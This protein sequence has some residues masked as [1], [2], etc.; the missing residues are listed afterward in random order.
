MARR[1]RVRVLLRAAAVLAGADRRAG[2]GRRHRRPHGADRV[3]HRARLPVEPHHQ[4]R[5]GRPRRRAGVARRAAHPRHR[6][7]RTSS[8]SASASRSPSGSGA[9]VEFIFIRRFFKAPRLILTVVTIGV[10]QI[11]AGVATGPAPR[12][13]PHDAAAELPVAVRLRRS[14][15]QRRLP[16]Q[17]RPGHGR[18][19]GRDRRPGRRSSASRTSA[20]PSGP[21][22]RAPTAPRCSASRS[23][24][25]QTVVWVVATVLA[26]VAVFL[27][28]GIVGLPDRQRARPDDPA[29]R[30]GRCSR[31]AGWSASRDLRRRR[32][33]S[34]SL[35]SGHHLLAPAAASSSTRSCSSSSSARCC[36]SGAARRRG[37]TTTRRRAGRRHAKCAPSRGAGRRPRDRA[38][39]P[40]CRPCARGRSCSRCRCLQRGPD[41]PR[42]GRRHLRDRRRLARRAHR[43]G[44]DRS[45]SARSRSSAS[46]RPSAGYLTADRGWDLSV[47]VSS[48][49][50]S[51]ARWRP[52]VIGL[53]A[54]RIRGLYLAVVTLSF[55]LATSSYLLDPDFVHWLPARTAIAAAACCSGA[56]RRDRG[57][58]TTSSVVA[59]LGLVIGAVRGL[60]AT[61]APVACSSACART[62]GPRSR[63][64]STPP[65]P[66]C[67]AFAFSGFIAA[68]AGALFVHHQHDLAA[69]PYS[70]DREPAASSSWS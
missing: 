5:P 29:A 23:S 47:A 16:R 36:S 32:S 49:R 65:R 8:P 12:L 55:A 53:P 48:A 4:L 61:A 41:Q 30:A 28:A 45:A 38:G 20:S 34:A 67:T 46:A 44:P 2:A 25:I 43:A 9:F 6:R 52:C 60:R 51:P 19:A 50:A 22:P 57:A 39:R 40:R 42:G 17:R 27:R 66:S 70:V 3:R 35:E 14:R 68:F 26:V 54:L 63:S 1:Q 59:C 10:S 18:G 58:L 31:S 37:S 33:A 21:A 69:Q 13:R 64:A 24:G 56:S 7:A 11:L 62:S 15:R